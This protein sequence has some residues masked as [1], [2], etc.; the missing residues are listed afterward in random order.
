MEQALRRHDAHEHEPPDPD[1]IPDAVSAF[2]E[3]D[4]PIRSD[5]VPESDIHPAQRDETCPACGQEPTRGRQ[6]SSASSQ[7]P[8]YQAAPMLDP[9]KLRP[10]TV[11]Y[12]HGH[13]SDFTHGLDAILRVE[14]GAPVTTRDAI[15]DILG[16]SH[17][18]IRPVIDL[19]Q[20]TPVDAYEAPTGLAEALQLLHPYTAT[21]YSTTTSR[22]PHIDKDH[23]IPFTPRT[24][25][26]TDGTDGTEEGDP[27]G[28][29]QTRLD[30]LAPLTRGSHRY[31]TFGPGVTLAQPILG[32]LLWRTRHGYSY[33]V[34][35]TGTHPL[36]K[37]TATEFHTHLT[38]LADPD[39]DHLDPDDQVT[40]PALDAALQHIYGNR[41]G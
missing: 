3:D 7:V 2:D 37:L 18:T 16:H 28:P 39:T 19:H 15:T 6:E 1:T 26:T 9:G 21:P 40:D 13:A 32:V 20:Q 34:D 31:K 35:N 10:P 17:V 30:N 12:L 24:S 27:V 8:A 5:L 29:G 33:Q 22:G 41:L 14:N 4:R 25:G 38:E 23:T 36:G 11:L